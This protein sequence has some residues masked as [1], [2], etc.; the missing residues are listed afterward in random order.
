MLGEGQQH[1][2]V[3]SCAVATSNPQTLKC[4][5]TIATLRDLIRRSRVSQL[6]VLMAV[7]VGVAA[8]PEARAMRRLLESTLIAIA[9]ESGVPVV[10]YVLRVMEAMVTMP[11]IL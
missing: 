6:A 1:E 7:A 11:L 8:V 3:V 9:G 5:A 10:C 4:S 2:I